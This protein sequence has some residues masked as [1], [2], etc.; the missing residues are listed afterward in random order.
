M[1][2]LESGANVANNNFDEMAPFALTRP[3]VFQLCWQVSLLPTELMVKL[4]VRV[5][6]NQVVCSSRLVRG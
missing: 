5:Q 1:V 6:F 2:T 3:G 4:V